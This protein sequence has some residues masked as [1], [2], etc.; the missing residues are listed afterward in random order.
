MEHL[1]QK[2]KC[3]IFY[4]IFKY[5]IF[6]RRQKALLWG[7]GLTLQLVI[8]CTLFKVDMVFG[9]VTG[10][11]RL[12]QPSHFTFPSLPFMNDGPGQWN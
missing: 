6:Q 12:V 7:K 5:M 4:N 1:H 9:K 11:I 8:V 3:S 2:S 10:L